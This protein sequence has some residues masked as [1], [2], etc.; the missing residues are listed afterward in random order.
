MPSGRHRPRRAQRARPRR[1]RARPC[2]AAGHRPVRHRAGRRGGRRP[3]AGD[4]SGRRHRRD[5]ARI[6]RSAR[7]RAHPLAGRHRRPGQ[8]AEARTGPPDRSALDRPADR[9]R[10][11]ASRARRH[12]G[13]RRQRDRRRARAHRCGGGPG[14]IVCRRRR[15]RWIGSDEFAAPRIFHRRGRGIRRPAWRRA[16][17]GACASASGG[18]VQFSGVGGHDMAEQGLASLFPIDELVDHR[19]R[20]DPAPAADDPA[21]HPRDRGGSRRGASPTCWSSSTARTSPIA[22]RAACAPQ[23]RT[24]RSWTMSRPRCG[25]GGRGGRAPCA[26][27]SIMC[28]RCCRSSRTCTASSA[29]RRAPTSDIR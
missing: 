20:G 1:H 2:A 6:C 28:W 5:A 22:S 14:Q 27:M 29:G 9:R 21:P 11:G 18:A 7:Q 13:R 16:D 4:R 12:R 17:A 10:R 24:F 3:R 26:P 8:G 25:R 19:L 23:P 15:R